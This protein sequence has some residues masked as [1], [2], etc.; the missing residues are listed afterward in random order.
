MG[1]VRPYNEVWAIE[2]LIALAVF[3]ALCLSSCKCPQI[4]ESV[5]VRDS[6]VYHDS[7]ITVHDTSIF[8][9]FAYVDSILNL[10]NNRSDTT[11][12]KTTKRG[13]TTSLRVA[14]GKLICEATIDSLQAKIDSIKSHVM[15]I[16]RTKIVLQDREFTKFQKWQFRLFWIFGIVIALFVAYKLKS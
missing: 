9:T 13:V 5:N 8:S 12:I 11:I 3:I 14:N 4:A 10:L 2:L 16:E 15:T 1:K 7:V 6:V